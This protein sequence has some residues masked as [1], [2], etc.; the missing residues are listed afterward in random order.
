MGCD[1]AREN[2]HGNVRG[3]AHGGMRG[4]ALCA[5]AFALY[6]LCNWLLTN[7]FFLLATPTAPLSRDVGTLVQGLGLLAL[8]LVSSRRPHALRGWMFLWLPVGLLAAGTALLLAGMGRS[9]A[10]VTLGLSLVELVSSLVIVALGCLLLQQSPQ[11]A[12]VGVLAGLTASL[13]LRFAFDGLAGTA[14]VAGVFCAAQLALVL[15]AAPPARTTLAELRSS[16]APE[17]LRLTN[18]FSFLP[19]NHQLYVC[20]ALFQLSYG[21]AIGFG[22]VGDTPVTTFAGIVPLALVCAAVL[23]LRRLPKIDPLFSVGFLFIVAGYLFVPFSHDEALPVASNLL[24]AGNSCFSL[25]YWLSVAALARRNRAGALVF[26]AW[27]GC[28]L[29]AGVVAGAFLGRLGSDLLFSDPVATSVVCNV[30]ALALIAYATLALKRFSFD[31]AIE[32][33]QSAAPI[34]T[35]PSDGGGDLARTVRELAEEARLTQRE[36]EVFAL[37]AQGRNGVYIQQQLG[38]SYNTVKTHVS[39]IYAKLGVHTHQELIDL[40]MRRGAAERVA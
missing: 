8:M 31:A 10:V 21:F 12:G 40:T 17:E 19:L 34:E 2:T 15:L 6:F 39:H 4:M 23:A 18:P 32:G 30:V 26:F 25:V 28:I 22:E 16:A 29:S 33:V 3:D 27:G 36:A 38:V 7:K 14:A 1:D 5:A 35:P 24:E 13:L 20:L 37:L 11:T 9:A